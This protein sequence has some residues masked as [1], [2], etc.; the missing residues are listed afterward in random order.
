MPKVLQPI[1]SRYLVFVVFLVTGF[2]LITVDDATA[3]LRIE[4]TEGQVAPTPIAIAEFT[5]PDGNVT[6]HLRSMK[7]FRRHEGKSGHRLAAVAD[8]GIHRA[9]V[10]LPGYKKAMVPRKAA[11]WAHIAGGYRNKLPGGRC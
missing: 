7:Y 10:L 1:F 9:L 3:Q 2:A 5:S 8:M 11:Y 6:A 4:I